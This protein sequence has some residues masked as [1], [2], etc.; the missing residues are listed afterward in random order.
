[1]EGGEGEGEAVPG[2]SNFS[3]SRL[4]EDLQTSG[5]AVICH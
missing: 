2:E 4:G 1:M 3:A 5:F